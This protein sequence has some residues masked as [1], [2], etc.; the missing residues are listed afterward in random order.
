MRNETG[1]DIEI[2]TKKIDKAR[3][4]LGHWKEPEEIKQPKQFLVSVKTATE[5]SD[6]IFIAG[7]TRPEAA[8]LYQG[9]FRPKV[10]YPLGQ[11]FLTDKQV[12]QIES[13]SLPKIMAKCGYNIN[14]A[15]PV[16]GGPKELGGAGFPSFLNTIGA[17]RVQH[18][19]KNWRTPW[20]DIGKALRIA[21]AWTQYS[22]GVSYPIFLNTSQDLSYVK[23]RTILSVSISI[24]YMPNILSVRMM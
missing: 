10:E 14:T 7:V 19:L 11:T 6:A 9:V 20:E 15:L 22:A 12:K 2:R 21:I 13:V 5:T 8:M 4:N 24:Q 1:E 18:F 17:S 23:G 16:R 3:K